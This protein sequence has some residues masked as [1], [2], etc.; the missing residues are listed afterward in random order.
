MLSDEQMA[1]VSGSRNGEWVDIPL[2][3]GRQQLPAWVRGAHVDWHDG[4]ANAPTV[5]INVRGDV[6]R[7][8]GMVWSREPGGMYIA[9]NE[10]G[11]A[12]VHHHNGEVKLTTLKRYRTADGE[13]HVYAPEKSG[14]SNIIGPD[15]CFSDRIQPGE[16]VDVEML[17]TTKQDGYGGAEITLNMV[18]GTELV[19]RGPWH[20]GA[21]PGYVEVRCCDSTL[22]YGWERKKENRRWHTRS[23]GGSLY[24]T[25]DLFMLIVAA[26]LPHIKV[27]AV[28][29]SYGPRLEAYRAEWGRLKYEIYE[30]ERARACNKK[31]AGPFWRTYWDGK[32]TY[33]GSFRKPEYGYRSEV[34]EGDRHKQ[35][36][37]DQA[38]ELRKRRG[39]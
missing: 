32:N 26:Y 15:C 39:Y 8:D 11:R 7:W 28:Q 6:M 14:L 12:C 33:C 5:S 35:F 9:R 29:K 16:W 22:R 25:Y 21:P 4:V 31:P 1:V 13:L 37:V 2:P 24:I 34:H 17:A 36:E 30:L 3:T 19:L 38:D 10:D 18:D 20:V 27:A 23:I